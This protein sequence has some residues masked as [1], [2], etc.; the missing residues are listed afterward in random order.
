MTPR[1]YKDGPYKG[2]SYSTQLIDAI[3]LYNDKGESK[4]LLENID[5]LINLAFKR[6]RYLPVRKEYEEYSD[7]FQD[8]RVQCLRLIKTKIKTSEKLS[9]RRLDAQQLLNLRENG[10][11]NQLEYEKNLFFCKKVL[12]NEP[13]TCYYICN[14]TILTKQSTFQCSLHIN[15]DN[16]FFNVKHILL[17]D[18]YL[19]KKIYRCSSK[20]QMSF[21]KGKMTLLTPGFLI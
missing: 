1:L 4:P 14:K 3:R 10:L 7:M 21:V 19:N 9:S 11:I 5:R 17:P 13:K 2:Q 6:E 15:Y 16:P 12:I 8:F 18:V 20:T